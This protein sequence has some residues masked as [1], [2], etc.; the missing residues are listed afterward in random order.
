MAVEFG[1]RLSLKDNMAA[2]LQRNLDLQR[3]FTQQTAQ[4]NAAVQSL[5]RTRVNTS[6]NATDNASGVI[7]TV[8]EGLNAANGMVADPDLSVTDRATE[9]INKVKDGLSKVAHTVAK[10]V[11]AVRDTASKGIDKIKT[12][13]KTV[14]K[15]VAKPFIQLK[16]KAS[17]IINKIKNGLKTIGKT[18]SLWILPLLILSLLLTLYLSL[19]IV[20]RRIKDL[21]SRL[22]NL[23]IP[24]LLRKMQMWIRWYR[25]WLLNSVSLYLIWLKE[26]LGYGVCNTARR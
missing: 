4:T 3:Q 6:I 10:P 12:G 16:D 24:L 20:D 13:L 26:V 5:G 25:I 21:I 8:R 19:R 9:V 18:V 7:R 15:T 17:P 11:V 2:T 23:R 1:V 14:G 22:R